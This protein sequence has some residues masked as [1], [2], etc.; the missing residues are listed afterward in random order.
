VDLT[1]ER[2]KALK[3]ASG[4]EISMQESDSGSDWGFGWLQGGRVATDNLIKAAHNLLEL[5][6][7]NVE[8]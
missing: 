8:V 4:L 2:D 3:I 6:F 5:Y 1:Y 7:S